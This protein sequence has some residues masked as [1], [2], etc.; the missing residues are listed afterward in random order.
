[1]VSATP[2]LLAACG[3]AAA[4]SSG[5]SGDAAPAAQLKNG[6][7]IQWAVDEGPTR[8]PLREDQVKLFKQQ[9]PN[10]NVE[11]ILGSTGTEKLQSLFAAGTP[12]DLFRQETAGMAFFASKSQVAAL[13][14]FLKRDKYDLADFFPTAWE[15]WKWKGKY[16]GLPFLGIRIGFFNRALATQTGAKVATTWKDPAWNFQAFLDSAQKLTV[17][18][19]T[20][21]SR[22]GAEVGT[23]RRDY[24]PWLWNNGGDLF[25]ADGTKIEFDQPPAMEA[26]EFIVDLIHKHR[27][28]PTPQEIQGQGNTAQRFQ[29]GSLTMYH[30]PVN[31]VASHRNAAN[32]DWSLFG[33]PKGKAKTVSSSGGGVGW[34]MTATSK[35][36]DETW[37]LMKVLGSK[38][39][40]R[41]EAVRGEAPPSRR[42]VANE[43][44][45]VNPPEPPKGDMKVVVEALEAI[46]VETALL[47]GVEIDRILGEELTPV[48]RGEKPLRQAI[49]DA[50]N[51]IRPLLNPAG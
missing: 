48:W 11:Y 3:G 13:D 47:N 43:P 41:L 20:V 21:V 5:P 38:E 25:N 40:V 39:G 4:P 15:L 46:H 29:N 32:F 16:Y 17:R 18:S 14:P 51:K 34:F 23:A 33:L 7:I 24:Q 12:P 8:T 50:E 30:A 37:E 10:L 19:G 42:S 2:I 35:V 45:F 31:G 1:V 44:A 49:A 27:V 26:F 6:A 22:F 36:K 9:F 28:S